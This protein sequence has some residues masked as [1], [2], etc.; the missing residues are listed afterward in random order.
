MLNVNN[1]LLQAQHNQP[2]EVLSIENDLEWEMLLLFLLSTNSRTEHSKTSKGKHKGEVQRLWEKDK[3]ETSLINKEA[4]L[5]VWWMRMDGRGMD[6]NFS[7]C[8]N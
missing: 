5:T 2:S 4:T 8:E 3:Q 7:S 6:Q 1:F